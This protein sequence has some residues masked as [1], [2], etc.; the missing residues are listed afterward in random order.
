VN[1]NY[2]LYIASILLQNLIGHFDFH[3]VLRPAI[4]L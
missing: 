3:Y 1:Q 4:W 2:C